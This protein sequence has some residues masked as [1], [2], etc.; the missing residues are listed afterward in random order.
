MDYRK[1]ILVFGLFLGCSQALADDEAILDAIDSGAIKMDSEIA[2]P[3]SEEAA[4]APAADDVPAPIL[5]GAGLG[6]AI[7]R[8]EE[9]DITNRAF[10]LMSA[11]WPFNGAV[12]CW[13]NPEAGSEADRKIVHDAVVNSWEKYSQFRTR[14]WEKCT[15]QTFGIRIRIDDVGPH[16]KFLGKYLAYN[17]AGQKT[18]VRDGMVLNFT[19]NNWS[20][21]CRGQRENCIKAIAVHEFG[22]AIGFAHE[23]NRPDTPGEC[24]QKPQGSSGD[25]LLTPWDPHS[26]MN[27]CHDMYGTGGALSELDIKAVMY[28]YG[29]PE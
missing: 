29:P 27:Y 23:Q 24:T 7:S 20:Q 13:E 8:A 19:F 3:P 12:V 2:I 9:E 16:A 10:P 17:R 15:D 1:S 26:V 6:L 4:P 21:S 11:K 14:G 5:D 28:I 18:V 25:T 22:H